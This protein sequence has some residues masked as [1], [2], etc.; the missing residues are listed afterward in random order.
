MLAGSGTQILLQNYLTE[1]LRMVNKAKQ[2]LT[3]L[4]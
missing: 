4:T 1:L 3:E 2:R